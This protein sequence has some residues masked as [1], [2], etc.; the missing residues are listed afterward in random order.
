MKN[1]TEA[2]ANP[3]PTP[4]E[5]T[6]DSRGVAAPR[7]CSTTLSNGRVIKAREMTG[8]DLIYM[9]SKALRNRPNL[10]KMAYMVS[11][12]ALNETPISMEEIRTMPAR[13]IKKVTILFGEMA[14]S[15]EE[16]DISDEDGE[17]MYDNLEDMPYE[18]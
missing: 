10:E 6:Q 9:D 2:P 3:R 1:I 11:N 15:E 8:K 16:E 13:D 12:L 4:K 5:V 7:I 14:G 17:E 18:P